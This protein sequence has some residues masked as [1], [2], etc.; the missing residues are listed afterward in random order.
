MIA[1]LACILL[2]LCAFGVQTLGVVHLGWLGLAV[3]AAAIAVPVGW[4][5][6]QRSG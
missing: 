2:A 3:L 6:F 5:T 1:L 4:P